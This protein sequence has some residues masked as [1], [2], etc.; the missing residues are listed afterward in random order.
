MILNTR[1]FGQ[2]KK[3]RGPIVEEEQHVEPFFTVL[4]HLYVLSL[5]YYFSWLRV[6]NLDGHEKTVWKAMNMITTQK[7]LFDSL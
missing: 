2:R 7:V 1:Y 6:L 3:D 4:S 5:S